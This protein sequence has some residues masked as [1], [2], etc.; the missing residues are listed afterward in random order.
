MI[1]IN[2]EHDPLD[3]EP[4]WFG[5]KYDAVGNPSR[6]KVYCIPDIESEYGNEETRGFG[7]LPMPR[8]PGSERHYDFDK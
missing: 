3:R 2:D 8:E 5:R 4:G 7:G 1:M 6:G